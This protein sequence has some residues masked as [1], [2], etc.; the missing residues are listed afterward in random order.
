MPRRGTKKSPPWERCDQDDQRTG[1]ETQG[2]GQESESLDKTTAEYTADR[3]TANAELFV[4]LD[5]CAKIKDRCIA[6]AETC[7]ERNSCRAV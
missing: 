6:K 3:E 2:P 5:Y 7:S 1:R 4:V